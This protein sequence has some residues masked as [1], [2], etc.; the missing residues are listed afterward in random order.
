MKKIIRI[1]ESDLTR[2]VKRVI[3]ESNELTEIGGISTDARSWSEIIVSKIKENNFYDFK[4]EG[5]EFP[6]AYEK[7]PVDYF[8]VKFL[9]I[10]AFGYD[11][12]NSGFVGNEYVVTLVVDPGLTYKIDTTII[13]H[14]MKH[15]YQDFKRYEN[16][17]VGIKDSNFI[18][19]MYTKDFE[20]FIVGFMQGRDRTDTLITILYLYYA[21]SKVEQDAYL[22]N[23]YDEMSGKGGG[24]GLQVMSSLNL[25]EK[26]NFSSLNDETWEK[27]RQANIPFIKKFKTKEEF[28]KYSEKY[29]KRLGENFRKKINKMKYLNFTASEKQS[30][31][32]LTN[33]SQTDFKKPKEPQ[34]KRKSNDK[35]L[36]DIKNNFNNQDGVKNNNDESPFIGGYSWEEIKK[37]FEKQ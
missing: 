6:E 32:K 30:E 15:A 17:S 25:L 36:E 37:I 27:L 5:K 14:E 23:I 13:N 28:A 18:K 33:D 21:L 24:Y 7:F 10:G 29:L 4:I 2:I 3:K 35:D 16:K 22:E 12:D 20:K 19:N 11:Q 34:P 26:L 1:T 9:P 8:K 31:S